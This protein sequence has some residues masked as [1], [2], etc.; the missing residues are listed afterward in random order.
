MSQVD[1]EENT[2]TEKSTLVAKEEAVEDLQIAKKFSFLLMLPVALLA[3]IALLGTAAY[4]TMK[5][6][7]VVP[8][9]ALFDHTTT[10]GAE[11]VKGRQNVKS[12]CV[13]LY[14]SDYR[15]YKETAGVRICESMEV[16]TSML[17]SLGFD[18]DGRNHGIS[19]IE[20]GPKASVT[21]FLG[22]DFTKHSVGIHA[23]KGVYLSEMKLPEIANKPGD[24]WND[25]TMSLIINSEI[26]TSAKVSKTANAY[27]LHDVH[28]V[29][30]GANCA[31]LY[32]SDPDAMRATTAVMACGGSTQKE[33]VFTRDDLNKYGIALKDHC[34][35]TSYVRTGHNVE[36][37]LYDGHDE[38]SS[39]RSVSFKANSDVDLSKVVHNPM[40]G[41]DPTSW[42][43]KPISFKLKMVHL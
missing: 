37:T 36:I 5:P 19:Y 29:P 32:G 26:G 35:G 30:P 18:P 6:S 42:D 31:V 24:D 3:F 33:W 23:N 16:T 43:N 27:E 22:K 9:I 12:G 39:T 20:T 4:V 28:N 14:G 38:A 8:V 1:I 40:G 11:I 41:Q 10:K 2:F 15:V 17:Q 25:K 21:L 34:S 13:T 7:E